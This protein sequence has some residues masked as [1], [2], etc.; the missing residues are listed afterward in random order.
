VAL[1]WLIGEKFVQ[2][3][4]G[5][6]NRTGAGFLAGEIDDQNERY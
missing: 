6:S 3:S 5:T 2:K 1:A 4:I